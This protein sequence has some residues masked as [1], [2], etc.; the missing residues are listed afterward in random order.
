MDLK[1]PCLISDNVNYLFSSTSQGL[2]RKRMP[3]SLRSLLIDKSRL[4][5]NF[6]SIPMT[7][8]DVA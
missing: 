6:V 3:Y 5:L 4:I 1:D 2:K 7:Q 8:Y